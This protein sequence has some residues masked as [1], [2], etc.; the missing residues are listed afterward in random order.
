MVP[1]HGMERSGP[2]ICYLRSRFWVCQPLHVVIL[3]FPIRE[4]SSLH[5]VTEESGENYARGELQKP[6][7]LPRA[8]PQAASCLCSSRDFG[9]EE[10]W[11]IEGATKI[12]RLKK[13]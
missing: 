9:P 3:F 5:S 10:A 12:L 1:T 7:S 4:A 8:F 11:R 6:A 2:H 13:D